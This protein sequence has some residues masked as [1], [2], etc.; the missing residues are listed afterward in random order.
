MSQTGGQ[1]SRPWV[2]GAA[3]ATTGLTIAA[4]LVAMAGR[5]PLSSSTPVNATSARAPITA[6][7][8][9][10]VGTGIVALGALMILMWPGRGSD[11]PEF[12]REPPKVHWISKGIAILVVLALGAVLV[13]AAIVGAHNRRAASSP[14]GGDVIGG[15]GGPTGRPAT[16]R[17]SAPSGFVLPSWLPWTV[18]AIISIAVVVAV[19]VLLVR[20]R[21]VV[22]EVPDD[23]VARSAVGAAI[24]ALDGAE[25][26]R[27]AVIAAYRAMEGTFAA[28]GLARSAT[29]APREYLT[30]VLAVRGDGDGDATTLT[31]L[32]EEARF[33]T[34]PISERIRELALRTLRTLRGRLERDDP[35]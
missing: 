6:L 16:A 24:G 18:I 21:T 12:V 10:L 13:A 34:H 8:M 32:F 4:A 5:S 23:D 19:V 9:L 17:R 20:H 11:E 33:S 25:D 26:P 22:D 7:F 28:H 15:I 31:N 27:T 29:E 3:L 14:V 1:R 35:Q 2:L 30:R